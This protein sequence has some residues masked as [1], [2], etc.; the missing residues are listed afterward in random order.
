M[1]LRC[2]I[3]SCLLGAPCRYDG[4]SK[5]V[6]ACVALAERLRAREG[7]AACVPVCPEMLGGLACPRPP[8]ER[9]GDRVMTQDGRDVTRAYADGAA[10]SLDI[11]RVHGA[12][13]AILKRRARRAARVASTTGRFPETLVPGDGVAAELLM[14]KGFTVVDEQLVS[15]CEPSFR[16]SYRHRFGKR[17]GR[18]GGSRA[19]RAPHSVR[20]C[21]GL[22]PTRRFPSRGT[23]S[24]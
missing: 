7:E 18:L 3:S 16:A 19:H 22:S 21:R 11:A 14:Q 9:I 20:G 12:T 4:G 13:L 17:S 24:R 1:T 15:Y 5:P 10:R 6:L 8:A 2:I 23:V